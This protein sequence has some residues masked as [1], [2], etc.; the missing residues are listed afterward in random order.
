M[1]SILISLFFLSL[2]L[3]SLVAQEAS[4]LSLDYKDPDAALMQG[5]NDGFEVTVKGN[6]KNKFY[7]LYIVRCHEGKMELK[8]LCAKVL[9]EADS[10]RCLFLSKPLS[11]DTIQLCCKCRELININLPALPIP[12][13]L[14]ETYPSET[15]CDTDC[16]P[17]MAFTTGVE[18]KFLIDGE[19]KSGLSFCDV[20]D[21]KIHP[22]EW[23]E[24]FHI[25]SYIYFE[26]E[27]SD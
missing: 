4:S 19:Y 16:L 7:K 9:C 13:I 14:M 6:F 1:K 18:K 22:S 17:I 2:H 20:R 26:F 24:R 11:K 3:T 8:E 25:K 12:Q 15:Y 27:L 23:H 10:V 21:S 5:F